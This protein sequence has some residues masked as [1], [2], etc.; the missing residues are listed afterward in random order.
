MFNSKNVEKFTKYL[1]EIVPKAIHDFKC[2]LDIKVR[3]ILQ[4]QIN[5]MNFI[6]RDE[7]EFQTQILFKTQEKIKQIEERLENLESITKLSNT[8]DDQL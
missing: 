3:K 8:K 4:K 5:C 6:N 2:D 1:Y 7:F